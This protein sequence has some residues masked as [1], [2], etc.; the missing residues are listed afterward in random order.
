MAAV[1]HPFVSGITDDADPDTVGSDEWNDDHVGSAEWD[2]VIVKASN[3]DVT[4]STTLVDDNDLQLAVLA[5]EIWRIR[6]ELIYAGT[7][8]T[9]DFKWQLTLSAG[10]ARGTLEWRLSHST[11]DSATAGE[12]AASFRDV[13]S[14]TSSAGGTDASGGKR[15]GFFDA[16]LVF[17]S[18]CT[19]KFQFAQN[20]A[21]S[22][23]VARV[24]AGSR[25]LAVKLA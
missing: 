6:I 15:T 14:Y 4:N 8:T 23:T 9:G 1:T 10:T 13:S 20:S 12:N 16:I 22:S 21:V 2:T 3:Q 7:S 24:C 5:N 18:S 25:L 11:N 19:Y 17:S